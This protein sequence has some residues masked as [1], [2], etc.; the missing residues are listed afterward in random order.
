MNSPPTLKHQKYKFNFFSP[1]ICFSSYFAT[2]LSL[3]VNLHKLSTLSGSPS[4]T[5]LH[6]RTLKPFCLS[7]NI[8]STNL[9]NYLLGKKDLQTDRQAASD[10]SFRCLDGQVNFWM[11][12]GF[13]LLWYVQYLIVCWFAAA[14]PAASRVEAVAISGEK[15]KS[16][17]TSRKLEKVENCGKIAD[18]Q[19]R[20]HSNWPKLFPQHKL[21]FYSFYCQ[22]TPNNQSTVPGFKWKYLQE[23][24]MMRG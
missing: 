4:S 11:T 23:I 19:F 3:R 1:Q 24:S 9:Q 2:N 10:L 15:N 17:K 22:Y 8:I 6:F 20:I 21:S 12:H 16:G 14:P 18:G 7:N 13:P 5:N